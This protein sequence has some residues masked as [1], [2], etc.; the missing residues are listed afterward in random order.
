MS[1]QDENRRRDG[2][3]AFG[4]AVCVL[5]FFSFPFL[6]SRVEMP[7]PPPPPT[8]VPAPAWELKALE[9]KLHFKDAIAQ[10]REF[11]GYYH[12]IE[13]TPEQE[14]ILSTIRAFVDKD[15]IPN[16]SALEHADEFPADLRWPAASPSPSS[17]TRST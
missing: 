11:M 8:T 14:D 13:L 2:W 9:G 7:G 6:L 12:T 1:R 5:V 16:A 17:R 3:Y 10:S 4:A 15:V